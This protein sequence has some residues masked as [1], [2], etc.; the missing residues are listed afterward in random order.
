MGTPGGFRIAVF[1]L[2][3]VMS[4]AA[5]IPASA[6]VIFSTGRKSECPMHQRTPVSPSPVRHN[7]CQPNHNFVM[8]KEPVNQPNGVALLH[9]SELDLPTLT[10]IQGPSA[11]LLSAGSRPPN[12]RLRI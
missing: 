1:V 6:L 5:S 11:H 3:A 9:V 4:T 12:L 10:N 7:R 2:V 8:L